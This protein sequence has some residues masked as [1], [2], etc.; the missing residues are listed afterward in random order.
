MYNVRRCMTQ[1]KNIIYT[2]SPFH[3]S[4]YFLPP[5][6]R[7]TK[8]FKVCSWLMLANKST[9]SVKLH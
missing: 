6:V 1:T 9:I 3:L 8:I 2:F 4:N 7:R 5:N